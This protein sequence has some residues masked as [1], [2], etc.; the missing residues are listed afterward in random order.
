MPVIGISP[1]TEAMLMT[2]CRTI[3]TVMPPATSRAYVSFTDSAMR[4]PA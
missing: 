2:A 4:M 1:V 3:M